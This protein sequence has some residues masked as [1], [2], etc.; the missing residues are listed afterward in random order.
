MQFSDFGKRGGN[1]CERPEQDEGIV[2]R[3]KKPSPLPEPRSFV[4]DGIDHQ[5]AA[6]D[7]ACR[8]YATL[9]GVFH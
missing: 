9:E 5:R 8:M 3:G 1:R 6:A 4:I 7:Q 2:P